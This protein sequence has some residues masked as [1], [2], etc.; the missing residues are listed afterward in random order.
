MGDGELRQIRR[1]QHTPRR[2]TRRGVLLVVAALVLVA[3]IGLSVWSL[4]RYHIGETQPIVAQDIALA[5]E[6]ASDAEGKRELAHT[7]AG[8]E[9]PDKAVDVQREL[10]DSPHAS[11]ADALELL[12]LCAVTAVEDKAACLDDGEAAVLSVRDELAMSDAFWA[13][14]ILEREER[15]DAAVALYERALETYDKQAVENYLAG[16]APV[17]SDEWIR[18]QSALEEHIDGLR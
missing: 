7:Y 8:A 3:V 13:A 18:T 14:V 5:E 16:R 12:R 11:P 2:I 10:L 17:E 9:E 15:S 4:L 6:E 1:E